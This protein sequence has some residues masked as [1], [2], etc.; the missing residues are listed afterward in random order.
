MYK[1]RNL[2]PSGRNTTLIANV[3]GSLAIEKTTPEL[4]FIVE[5]S[6]RM[7]AS[8]LALNFAGGNNVPENYKIK[9]L[10]EASR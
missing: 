3:R 9:V 8:Q 7:S 6:N 5:N 10:D 4:N 2:N 1:S